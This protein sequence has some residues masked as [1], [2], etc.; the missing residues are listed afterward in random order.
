MFT[1]RAIHEQTSRPMKREKVGVIFSAL[2]A[3]CA[4][5]RRIDA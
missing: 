4:D 3:G 2:L 5:E 1:V